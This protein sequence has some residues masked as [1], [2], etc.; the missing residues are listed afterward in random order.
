MLKDN[1]VSLRKFHGMTQEDASNIITLLSN[2]K[3][4]LIW[5]LFIENDDKT[6]RV[7]L[8]SRFVEIEPLAS[9]YHGG[10]HACASGATV[11]SEE[12]A[13]SLIAEADALLSGF[14][15]SHPGLI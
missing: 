2:I 12:E 5:L 7:R 1:L 3:G 10:G 15:K 6:V 9:R 13:K 11:Y 4:S 14:K 8:R